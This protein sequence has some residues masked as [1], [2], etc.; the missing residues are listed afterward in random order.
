MRETHMIID[1][2]GEKV[3]FKKDF[4]P[5]KFIKE[6]SYNPAAIFP[7]LILLIYHLFHKQ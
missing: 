4:R 2:E 1:I 7:L 6:K 3:Y 5:V